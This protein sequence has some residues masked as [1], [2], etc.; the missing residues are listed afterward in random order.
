ML[1]FI[2]LIALT[3]ACGAR[4][5]PDTPPTPPPPDPTAQL[6]VIFSHNPRTDKPEASTAVNDRDFR[7]WLDQHGHTLI[8]STAATRD[9]NGKLDFLTKPEQEDV[10]DKPTPWITISNGEKVLHTSPQPAS[11]DEIQK[12]ILDAAAAEP[13]KTLATW[14]DGHQL[15]RLGCKPPRPGT[16]DRWRAWGSKPGEPKEPPPKWIDYDHRHLAPTTRDQNGQSS[17]TAAAASSQLAHAIRRAGQGIQSLSPGD[18]YYRINR[19]RDNGAALED[20][21]TE[22]T[23]VGLCDTDHS[24]TWAITERQ[25]AHQEGYQ[26][27]R[28]EHRATDIAYCAT[29]TDAAN[30]IQRGVDITVITAPFQRVKDK[31]KVIR[32]TS[33]IATDVISDQQRALL[34]ARDLSACGFTDN[35]D[36]SRHM[37]RFLEILIGSSQGGRTQPKE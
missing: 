17:C 37:L 10:A 23:K 25:T 15:R 36:L 24:A 18:L 8:V 16:A 34:A 2:L 11:I 20:A 7:G 9:Q 22:I 26:I 35:P 32:N 27:N 33:L 31:V 29:W 21:V 28:T 19:G 13:P 30:A 12:R 1:R 14:H 3:L 6:R 4:V 5:Q